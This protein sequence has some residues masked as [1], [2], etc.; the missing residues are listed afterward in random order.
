MTSRVAAC[1]QG[2]FFKKNSLFWLVARMAC[3]PVLACLATSCQLL[4]DNALLPNCH[5]MHHMKQP[6]FKEGARFGMMMHYYCL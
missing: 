4:F 2:V 3:Y 6:L 5:K 1:L